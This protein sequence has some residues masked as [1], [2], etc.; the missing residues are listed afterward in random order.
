MNI[1]E[2]IRNFRGIPKQREIYVLYGDKVK[3]F[4]VFKAK[5]EVSVIN[6]A[7]GFHVL[8]YQFK[9]ADYEKFHE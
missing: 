2:K 4:F 8:C 5:K 7:L 3:I 1:L 6:K 9:N